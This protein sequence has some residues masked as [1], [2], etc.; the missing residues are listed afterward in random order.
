MADSKDGP[1][2]DPFTGQLLPDL[3]FI[4]DAIEPPR[5]R[6]AKVAQQIRDIGRRENYEDPED[7][8]RT[9]SH[10]SALK[11]DIVLKARKDPNKDMLG[12]YQV[13]RDIADAAGVDA[14]DLEEATRYQIGE[15][16]RT[17]KSG[18]D[19]YLA[20]NQGP[21]GARTLQE[22][23][24]GGN[25]RSPK[26]LRNMA[27]QARIM[28]DRLDTPEI[29]KLRASG[30]SR[31]EVGAARSTELKRR[32]RAGET[33]LKEEADYFQKAQR[34]EYSDRRLPRED[35]ISKSMGEYA[36]ETLR[37]DKQQN[38]GIAARSA[39]IVLNA[40]QKAGRGEGIRARNQPILKKEK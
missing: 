18:Y 10:E 38:K 6:Q 1:A 39:P 20:H 7:L 16:E 13:R 36:V 31:S 29:K 24:A 28:G 12:A 15:R 26:V 17:G 3:D 40:F 11:P 2:V 25:K 5:G 22:W 23:S 34:K 33:T 14:L 30:A 37:R 21:G 32:I 8:V 19:F 4:E 27:Y 35:A 9:A